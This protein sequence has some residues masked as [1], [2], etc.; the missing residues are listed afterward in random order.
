MMLRHGSMVRRSALI[1]LGLLCYVLVFLSES[2]RQLTSDEHS[3]HSEQS[4]ASILAVDQS[5]ARVARLRSVCASQPPAPP[6]PGPGV[7]TVLLPG[8]P[9]V[10]VCVPHKVSHTL[11]SDIPHNTL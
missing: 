7:E 3:E 1:A 5:E 6:P 9:P 4:E 10:T 8:Q 11:I 2:S